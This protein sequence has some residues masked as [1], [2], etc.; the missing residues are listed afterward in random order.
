[1][2]GSAPMRGGLPALRVVLRIARRDARRARGRSLLVIAMIALPVLGIGGLD[3]LYRTYQ[4]SPDQE[5]TRDIGAADIGI[6]DTQSGPITQYSE[7]GSFTASASSPSGSSTRADARTPD[8]LAALLP[9]GSR[10]LADS[11]VYG[12]VAAG[13]RTVPTTIRSLAYDD[14]MARGIY[15][16]HEG[17][18]PRAAGEV[19]LTEALAARLGVG[20]GDSIDLGDAYGPATVVGVVKD[21]SDTARQTALV[22]PVWQSTTDES[23]GRLLV[24]LPRP[25]DAALV[26]AA[27]AEGVLVRGRGHLPGL[28]PEPY[29][30]GSPLDASTLTA[31]SLVAGMALLEIVLLA[32]PSFAVGAKRQSHDLALLSAVGGDRRDVRRVVLGGGAVLGLTAGVVGVGLGIVAARAGLPLAGRFNTQVPG[33]FDVRPLE[34]LGVVLVGT[35]TAVLA[36]VVPAWLAA[37]QDVVNALTGR[38]GIVR[39]SRTVPVIGLVAA[40]IGA[41]IALEGARRR[42]LNVV[43]AGSI[44]AEL[45]LVATTPILV[46]ACGRFGR[47]L[48]LAPRLALRDAARNRSRTAPAVAAILAAVAGSVAVATVVTSFDAK[49]RRQYE[50]SAVPGTGVFQLFGGP[51]SGGGVDRAGQLEQILRDR[52]P[53]REVVRVPTIG[54]NFSVGADLE[55]QLFVYIESTCSASGG[56]SSG[57]QSLFNGMPVGGAKVLE[58]AT[59]VTSPALVQA[60]GE[61]KAVLPAGLID[62]D[63]T[64]TVVVSKLSRTSEAPPLRLRVPAVALPADAPHQGQGVL[65]PAIAARVGTTSD[66]AGLVVFTTRTPTRAEQDRAQSALDTAGFEG[67]FYVERGYHST[68]S[69]YLLILTGASALL[70]LGAS[71]IATGL[72]AADGKADL[73]TL[74]AVGA[75]PGL[76]RRLA[77]F[78]SLVTSGLGTALGV[79]AGLVPAAGLI[80]ALNTPLGQ[81][82]GL[83]FQS[84]EYP[85]ELPWHNLVLTVFVVPLI[86]G[87]AAVLLTRSRLPLVRRPA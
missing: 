44:V 1:M 66:P 20:L 62:A 41:V 39:S 72:A 53:V 47:L 5:A 25:A 73:S 37:R 57:S 19:G 65:S 40:V 54:Q 35:G 77:G 84:G 83:S 85:F 87:L 52:L 3:V 24:D 43:L 29:S 60:L 68:Y 18:P 10:W 30:A 32:G 11:S 31:V 75:T 34:L 33:P 76:R 42:D 49:G 61:G 27:N 70:V 14:P 56:C 4:L 71:G 86:A 13:D 6:T 7:T 8:Q 82:A 15:H 78:Q 59:G 63:G 46:G 21:G 81:S 2:K 45:G 74:A 55:D 38:R 22:S 67:G 64:A 79:V 58:A 16:Q 51:G 80:S 50:T 9:S 26:H 36:A 17:R 48:A 69:V 23:S 28:I 12:S